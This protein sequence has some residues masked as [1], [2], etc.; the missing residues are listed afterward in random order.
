[1]ATDGAAAALR[2]WPSG[3][4]A[5]T[6]SEPQTRSLSPVR[7]EAGPGIYTSYLT[8]IGLYVNSRYIYKPVMYEFMGIPDAS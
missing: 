6:V 7:R 5:G 1:M 4:V 8:Y 3:P 2:R